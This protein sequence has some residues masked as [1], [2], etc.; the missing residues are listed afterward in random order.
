MTGLESNHFSLSLIFSNQAARFPVSNLLIMLRYFGSDGFPTRCVALEQNWMPVCHL[1]PK[2]NKPREP[3]A[4]ASV[5]VGLVEC[6]GVF[7][8]D[9]KL[10]A[11]TNRFDNPIGAFDDR[12][13]KHIIVF[14]SLALT[15]DLVKQVSHDAMRFIACV[16]VHQSLSLASF[17]K[18]LPSI[19][20]DRPG[21]ASA[22]PFDDRHNCLNVLLPKSIPHKTKLLSDYFQKT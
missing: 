4:T 11:V 3:I 20:A 22:S 19:Q 16:R 14:A 7:V 15:I 10:P 1:L 21:L 12:N 13:R 6:G 9:N 8:I 5:C 18:Q 17:F 2:Q